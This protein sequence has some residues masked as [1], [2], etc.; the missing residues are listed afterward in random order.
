VGDH[1]IR[2][3]YR[4]L[5][6]DRFTVWSGE[7]E[8]DVRVVSWQP[9]QLTLEEDSHRWHARITFDDDRAYVHTSHF[10]VGLKRQPRFPDKSQAIPAGGCVAPMPGKVVELRV[11]EGDTV[12]AGQVL[13]IMEAMK[14][15]HSVTAPQAGT[16]AHVSVAAG[17]Q[18]DADALLIIVS[19]D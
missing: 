12:Q 18:V 11:A 16:V 2:V 15:E 5:G 3:D 9:P 6:G 14:M 1:E 7:D 4:H 19:D 13:L 10:S 17:D 8:R